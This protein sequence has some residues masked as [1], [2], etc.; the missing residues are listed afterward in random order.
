MKIED[1]L[2]KTVD[3]N[4]KLKHGILLVHSDKLNLHLKISRGTSF[5]NAV[6]ADTLFHGASVGKT[7]IAALTM[8]LYEQ[9]ILKIE[10]KIT[11]YL[12]AQLLK[13]LFV[14]DGDDYSTHVTI[15]HLMTHTSGAADYYEH[16]PKGVRNIK[17]IMLEEPDKLWTPNEP[18]AFAAEH[19]NAV[20]KPGEKFHYSDTGYDLLGYVL[21]NAAGKSLHTLVKAEILDPL[22]LIN[23]RWIFYDNIDKEPLYPETFV[24]GRE[25]S[26]YKSVSISWAGGNLL[27]NTEDLYR[28]QRALVE[29]HVVEPSSRAI[30]LSDPR[31]FAHGI[32]YSCG[33]FH[34]NIKKLS[35][36]L[37]PASLFMWGK[38]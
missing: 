11:K 34:L 30:M 17:T 7:H 28:F 6:T 23:T 21:E 9:G 20:G 2:N 18:L 4:K 1:I 10:D 31:R 24:D 12:P 5:G 19:L 8:R 25:V 13:G 37:L 27:V 26:R 22:E 32:D 35:F 3:R 38:L 14:V 16:T 15:K 29:G 33:I 36:G